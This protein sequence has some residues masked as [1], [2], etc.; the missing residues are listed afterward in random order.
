MRRYEVILTH[1]IAVFFSVEFRGRKKIVHRSNYKLY[2]GKGHSYTKS[3]LCNIQM[4]CMYLFLLVQ[5]R[6]EN[7]LIG[8]RKYELREASKRNFSSYCGI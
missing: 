1:K 2:L 3:V 8:H 5:F 4:L 7:V 6:R